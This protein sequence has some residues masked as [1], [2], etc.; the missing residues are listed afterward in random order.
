M[1]CNNPIELLQMIPYDYTVDM[2]FLNQDILN[3]PT[4]RSIN[5]GRLKIFITNVE[6]GISD[7]VYITTFGIDGPATT[8][9]L[10]Y[11][12]NNITYIVDNTRHGKDEHIDTY[13]VTNI[14]TDIT[15]EKN[16]IS[17][18]YH[19]VTTEGKDYIIYR[20]IVFLN[21]RRIY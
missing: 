21:V 3:T 14:Y 9:I 11:D 2:A 19:V 17:T 10:K 7:C 4:A 20:D 15:S 13:Y 12:G 1:D 6:N 16:L 8:S 5:T 18:N